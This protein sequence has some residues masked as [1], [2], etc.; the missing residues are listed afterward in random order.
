MSHLT[1]SLLRGQHTESGERQQ[2]MEFE[3][4][5]APVGDR[6]VR[7]LQRV[8]E[9]PV[10]PLVEMN[11]GVTSR[12]PRPDLVFQSTAL[13]G[14]TTVSRRNSAADTPTAV[15]APVL[16]L[17]AITDEVVRQIDRR[18]VATRERMGKM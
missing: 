13:Q 15:P 2:Q 7:R 8:E 10:Y 18:L 4:L 5:R 9:L 12:R 6:I 14:P 11:S 1:R 3:I 16:N 17:G